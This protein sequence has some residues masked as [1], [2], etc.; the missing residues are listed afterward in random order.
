MINTDIYASNIPSP[1]TI[2]STDFIEVMQSYE[3]NSVRINIEDYN[4]NWLSKRGD[5]V[6]KYHDIINFSR[7][8]KSHQCVMCGNCNSKIPCQNKDVC[9]NCD[10][11]FW[12]ITNLNLVIKFCKGS[13][14]FIKH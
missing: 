11:A 6:I 5:K 12:L 9:K 10:S 7:C 14:S 2:H 8:S 4:S 3:M 13:F 1:L